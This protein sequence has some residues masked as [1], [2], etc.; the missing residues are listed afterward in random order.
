MEVKLWVLFLL[1]VEVATQ[2]C[3]QFSRNQV[4]YH[5]TTIISVSKIT[6][7]PDCCASCSAHN[8]ARNASAPASS[9]C[10]V[11]VWYGC[12]P[13]QFTCAL[14]ATTDKPFDSTCVAA[15]QPVPGPGPTP[16]VPL[17]FASIYTD[18]M[19]LQSAPAKAMVWGFSNEA[20][21]NALDYLFATYTCVITTAPWPLFLIGF[22]RHCVCKH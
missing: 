3:S 19:V 17:R 22:R 13:N 21:A 8:A 20:G 9:Y 7:E 2:K 18:H 16:I 4:D 12:G 11:G 15:M 5:D 1:L 14:K 6:T 10:K